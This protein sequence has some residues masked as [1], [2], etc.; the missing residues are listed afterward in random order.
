MSDLYYDIDDLLYDG[1][2][3]IQDVIKLNSLLTKVV[4]DPTELINFG[5]QNIV[6]II[7][8]D[9]D[10]IKRKE[11]DW[12]KEYLQ[13][14]TINRKNFTAFF[15]KISGTFLTETIDNKVFKEIFT[16]PI[17]KIYMQNPNYTFGKPV[18]DETL[19][20]HTNILACFNRFYLQYDFR[21]R[22]KIDTLKISILD[23]FYR[24]KI[25]NTNAN[26]PILKAKYF[27]DTFNLKEFIKMCMLNYFPNVG[28]RWIGAGHEAHVR[29]L[30]I[31]VHTLEL[32]L[33]EA[34]EM[35]D[36]LKDVFNKTDT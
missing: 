29:T 28:W 5:P 25:R 33:W 12:T 4:D 22:P 17:I 14:K 31:L 9:I 23:P 1:I 7:G 10:N 8:E 36:L 26:D 35:K 34:N 2:D 27:N 16:L 11:F 30:E 21:F 19:R 15:L 24:Q 13:N 6:K 3:N 20:F 18:Y 32:G